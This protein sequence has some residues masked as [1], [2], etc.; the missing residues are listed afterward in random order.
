MHWVRF[1][2]VVF[3]LACG[4]VWGQSEYPTRPVKIVVPSPP[5]GGTDIVARVLAQ[6]YS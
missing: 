2:T 5:G 6:H 3:L 4:Q 1:F